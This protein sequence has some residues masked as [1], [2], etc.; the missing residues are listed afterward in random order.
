V[1]GSGDAEVFSLSVTK[2][3]VSVEGG[4]VTSRDAALVERIRHMRNYGIQANYNASYPGLNGKMS[5]FHAIVGLANLKHLD[6]RMACRRRTSRRST[7]NASISAVP[8]T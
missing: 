1:G 8:T 5:E 7:R 4:M 6:A 2:V 3:L